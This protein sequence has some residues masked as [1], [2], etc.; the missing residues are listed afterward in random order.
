LRKRGKGLT[1]FVSPKISKGKLERLRSVGT[2]VYLGKRP[3]SD[4]I[5]Y[6]KENCAFN[7]RA[8]TDPN[9]FMG[10]KNLSKELAKQL[11]RVGSLF[12]P[13]SSGT[14]CYGVAKGFEE[15]GYLPQIHA[16]QTSC[17]N[18]IT[19]NFDK[20][21]KKTDS[22]I[23]DALVAKTSLLREPL[24]RI[25]RKSGGFGWVVGDKDIK[26]AWSYLETSGIVTSYEGAA[27]LAAV[28]KAKEK[29]F[30]LKQPIVSLLSGKYYE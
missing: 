1:V 23:A 18:I 17:N 2:S 24:L 8:S 22:S 15:S 4:A 25:I 29:K 16:V 6:A 11:G 30:E 10:Y 14:L 19:H 9:G 5:K 12:I 3:I 21:F 7:L 13:V 28:W 26:K 20:D 27:T